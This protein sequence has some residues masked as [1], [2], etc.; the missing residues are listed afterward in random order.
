MKPARVIATMI[1]CLCFITVGF[2]ESNAEPNGKQAD[3]S[4]PLPP[5][6]WSFS[7]HPYFGPG[8]DSKPVLVFSVTTSTAGGLAVNEIGL[9][10]LSSKAVAAVKLGWYLCTAQSPGANLLQGQTPLIALSGGI[11][12]GKRRLLKFPVLSFAKIHKSL[13][14]G[15]ALSADFQVEVEVSE[16]L[17][18]DGTTYATNKTST[19]GLV[20][21]V[22]F[23]K[24][25]LQ[26]ACARQKCKYVANPGAHYEC[27]VSTNVEYCNNR[28]SSC[29]N[30]LC[31]EKPPGAGD[32]LE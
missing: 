29:C 22:S 17:Y 12:V 19:T 14:M 23:A 21:L 3:K 20:K 13:L 16:V 6:N 9:K 28:E 15:N 31:G 2:T 18:E 4:P 25:V 5:G 8:Y 7:A 26:A 11:P 1:F 30:V 10:N 27:D 32:I 24:P